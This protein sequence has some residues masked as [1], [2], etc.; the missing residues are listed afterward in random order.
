MAKEQCK[1]HN[2]GIGG[3][4]VLEGVMMRCG[5]DY[6]VAIRKPDKTVTVSKET[7]HGILE[8]SILKKTPFVRGV[9]V[10][11]DSLILG[12]RI[13]SYSASFYEEEEEDTKKDQTPEQAA[14]SEK[15]DKIM[16]GA[17]TAVA[18]VI[19][20]GLFFVLPYLISALLS[21]FIHHPFLTAVIEGLLRIGIFMGYILAISMMEDIRRLFQYHGAE[22]KCINCLEHGL[23]LN[24]ENVRGSTRF[25]KR[26]GTSFIIFVMLVSIVLFFFIRVDNPMLRI[27]LRI[28][29]IPMISGISFELIRLAGSSDNPVISLLSKPGIWFQN[30]TTREPDDD[31]IRVGIAS[32]E[33]VFDWRDYLRREFGVQTEAP[34]E[35]RTA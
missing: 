29:L 6:A 2:S 18:F 31:M 12:M 35:V 27:L 8:G 9:F 24:V 3:Q 34:E 28:L 15:M 4:A 10:F 19:A 1:Q 20:I 23:P 5:D 33:A 25:H 17:V 30:L 16:E 32:V 14:R 13:T 26:C 7:Y 21:R 11:L 22:H